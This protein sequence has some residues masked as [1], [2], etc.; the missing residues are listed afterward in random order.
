MST[1][2]SD[3][4]HIGTV[5][6]TLPPSAEGQTLAAWLLS[7]GY[8]IPA[9]C[10]GR[11]VCGKCK[12]RVL[13]GSFD[14]MDQ[15]GYVLACQV[16]CPPGGAELLLPEIRGE[17]LTAD[18]TP[19]TP[20]LS[21]AD[22]NRLAQATACPHNPSPASPPPDEASYGLALDI[23]TTT[24]AL[25]LVDRRPSLRKDGRSSGCVLATASCLNPQYSLGADV[26]SRIA[27][28]QEGHLQDLQD[29]LLA[30]V[31]SLMAQVCPPGTAEIPDMMVVGNT[32][33]LHLF[34]G[35]SP[36]G[37]G[38]YPFTPAFTHTKVLRGASL[39]LPVGTVTLL[40]SISAF[41]GADITAGMLSCGMGTA[42]PDTGALLSA[43]TGGDACTAAT[44]T[45]AP[46]LLLDIGTNGEMVLYT[47]ES[48]TSSDA[49]RYLVASTAA[50]PALEGANISCGL[51]G[52][53]GAVCSVLPDEQGGYLYRTISDAP[54]RGLCGC[55]LVD[56]AAC[57]CDSDLLDE[58]GYLDTEEEA[59]TLSGLWEIAGEPHAPDGSLPPVV[60]SVPEVTLTQKDIRE[61]QLAKSALRAG[62]EALLAEAGMT[63]ETFVAAHGRVFLAGGLGY[64][65]RAESAVRIGLLPAA[66]LPVTS[67]VGNSALA[68][69]VRALWDDT[70]LRTME[71]CTTHCRVVELHHSEVFNQ[72]FI[73]YMMFPSDTCEE[74]NM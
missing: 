63:A 51:G 30:A 22:E 13:R 49:A 23:G 52:V 72:G 44:P 12:V 25:A 6:V 16:L 35:I 62:M 41:V 19:Q 73:E 42:A 10:G 20:S 48:H 15:D 21:P 55:G 58:T 8:A 66:L 47:G 17:G 46:S 69:A 50:G 14:T 36:A 1:S 28:S 43:T 7:A 11:G 24:L 18:A 71:A 5:T 59:V 3:T 37:M 9:P 26:I 4:G 38:A 33:M 57:L 54:A 68:G 67:A 2:V 61:L 27:A 53:P 65:L 64:Y 31:R 56:F 29:L 70:A 39:G 60:T 32:T 74:D 40:P 45:Q 34:C